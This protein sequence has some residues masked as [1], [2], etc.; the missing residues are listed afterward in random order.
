MGSDGATGNVAASARHRCSP[1]AGL[2][3]EVLSAVPITSKVV[4][5]IVKIQVI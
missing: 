1:D 5:N 2:Q 3:L 4:S